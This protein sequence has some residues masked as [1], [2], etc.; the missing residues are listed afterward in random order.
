MELTK[1]PYLQLPEK[2]SMIVCWETDVF[3]TSEVHIWNA[4][5]PKCGIV[6]YTPEGKKKII[7]GEDAF[8]HKVLIPDL[9]PGCDYCYCVTSRLNDVQVV[10]DINVF[11]TQAAEESAISFVMTSETGGSS[12]PMNIV[13]D[14]AQQIMEERPDFL[15]LL[16][17]MVKDGLKKQDWD[18]FMYFPFKDLLGS[19]PFYHCV[20]N[21][22]NHSPYMKDYFATSEAGYYDFQYGCAHFVILDSTQMS[23]HFIDEQGNMEIRLT[24]DLNLENTQ[25]QFLIS[26]LEKNTSPWKF[27]CLHYPPYFSGT[28]EATV[29]RPLCRIFEKYHVDCVFTSHAIVYER[30]HPLTDNK[31]DFHRG[32]RYFVIGGAGLRPKWFHHKKAWH[33]AKS[34]AVPHFVHVSITPTHLE[35]QAIDEEGRLFDSLVLDK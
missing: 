10:S 27:V 29:L 32:V 22:E 28:W 4:V 6:K 9:I 33:T 17:D 18:K 12:S 20:G 16:G 31:I 1:G 35:L 13:N 34:R 26:A 15:L 25:I 19:I 7:C 24:Q 11:R 14:I 3:C 21:H 2:N 30:S 23:D 8:V 5:C